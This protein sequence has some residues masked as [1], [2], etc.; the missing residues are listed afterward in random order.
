MAKTCKR[1]SYS[2]VSILGTSHFRPVMN[3][4]KNCYFYQLKSL[5][6][7]GYKCI[8][9]DSGLEQRAVDMV[10]THFKVISYNF[11]EYTGHLQLCKTL[12]KNN[13]I[14]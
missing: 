3:G 11:L 1:G 14:F 5:C 12:L 10:V 4:S 6:V 9:L 2:S 8:V 7:L 13:I